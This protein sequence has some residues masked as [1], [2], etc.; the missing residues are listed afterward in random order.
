MKLVTAII[1]DTKYYETKAA[2]LNENFFSLNTYRVLG[3]GREQ[4]QYDVQNV[5]VRKSIIDYPF[6]SKRIIEIYLEEKDVERLIQILLKVNRTG[7]KGD[8]KIFVTPLEEAIRIRTK[9]TGID[10]LA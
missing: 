10:A 7:N 2:L 1:R 9:E 5:G 3:R 6:V 4:Q 8:G